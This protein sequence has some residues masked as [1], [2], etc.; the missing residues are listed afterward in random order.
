MRVFSRE[1]EKTFQEGKATDCE[2]EK[3][4]MQEYGLFSWP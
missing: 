3:R 1:G 2:S 4:V